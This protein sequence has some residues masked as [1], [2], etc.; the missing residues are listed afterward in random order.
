MGQIMPLSGADAPLLHTDIS[1]T[2]G[3][4]VLSNRT[5]LWS[6]SGPNLQP[7]TCVRACL[8]ALTAG[9]GGAVVVRI[10]RPW[11]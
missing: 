6:L 3:S 5:G 8:A 1:I 9:A 10:A 4:E 11:M 2:S 7:L